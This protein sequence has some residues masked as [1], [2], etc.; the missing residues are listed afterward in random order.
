MARG[1]VCVH[2]ILDASVYLEVGLFWVCQTV[3]TALAVTQGSPDVDGH[4]VT[5]LSDTHTRIV[6]ALQH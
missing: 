6:W 4:V 5:S 1:L 3:G 2:K